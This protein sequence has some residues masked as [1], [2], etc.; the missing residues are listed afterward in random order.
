[1]KPILAVLAAGMGS[2][3]GGLKQ[4]DR[5]G[6]NGE[7]L[8]DYSVFDALKAGFGKVV[9]IIRHDFEK[10][11][12]DVVLKRFKDSFQY[13]IVY[14]ELD[15]CI[16]IG[17]ISAIGNR[18]KPWGTAHAILCAADQL[19]A[20]FA[21]INSDDFYGRDAYFTLAKFLSDAKEEGAIV[22]YRLDQTLSL[23]GNVTRGICGVKDGYLTSVDELKNIAAESGRIF[24]TVGGVK[25]ELP[26]STMVSMNF[27]GFPPDIFPELNQYFDDFL[28]KQ[29]ETPKGE[30]YIPSFVDHLV[31]TGLLNVR[32]LTMSTSWF[33]VTYKEDRDIAIQRIAELTRGGVYP[34]NLWE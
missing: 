2:R 11:F 28:A 25:R 19:D 26:A 3:Y 1:M 30:C 22:P 20:P 14:Q 16:P 4:M 33:G 21:V 7:V 10:D 12:Q 24:S 23:Q 9:F 18:S 29:D 34:E 32:V 5:L 8:L 17:M 6:K 13:E 31:R 27:W 15:S